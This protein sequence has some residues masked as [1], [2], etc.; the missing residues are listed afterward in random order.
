[1]QHEF[2][3]REPP[4]PRGKLY[5]IKANIMR[6]V[7]CYLYATTLGVRCTPCSFVSQR[8]LGDA[9][10]CINTGTKFH[11]FPQLRAVP[12][13]ALGASFKRL[14]AT[15]VLHTHMTHCRRL[16]D[17][18]VARPELE[19]TRFPFGHVSAGCSTGMLPSHQL[20]E[21]TSSR[22]ASSH[23]PCP[24]RQLSEEFWTR[25]V[26]GCI[27]NEVLEIRAKKPQTDRRF[28]S[29]CWFPWGDSFAAVWP[30]A[31]ATV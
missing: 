20:Q 18:L 5:Y 31:H 23:A 11:H 16:R 10:P 19:F 29:D 9:A 2:A 17:D 21:G 26:S 24:A 30:H 25:G 4:G 22:E 27:G 6:C 8:A 15:G 28:L 12:D 7:A 13:A 1:M 14:C 3:V